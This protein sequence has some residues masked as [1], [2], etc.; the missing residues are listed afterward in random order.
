MPRIQTINLTGIA[1]G[2]SETQTL[3]V[4]ATSSNPALIPNPTVTY[5][6]PNATGSLSYTACKQSFGH[7]RHHRHGDR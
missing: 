1:A 6:S 2:G 4:T 3:T 7:R 5:T